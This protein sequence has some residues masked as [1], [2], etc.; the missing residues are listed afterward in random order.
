MGRGGGGDVGA[1]CGGERVAEGGAGAAA[2][3]AAA[4]GGAAA[5]AAPEPVFAGHSGF[6][7]GVAA[8]PEGRALLASVSAD[9]CALLWDP[10]QRAAVGV[11][12]GVHSD[13]ANC[14]AFSPDGTMLATVSE[15][16][17]VV[18]CRVPQ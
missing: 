5:A 15:S 2:A 13:R 8:A 9:R 14:V 11:V 4:G 16:G 7:T 1:G 18:V 17:N 12:E 6:V 10:T 3:A